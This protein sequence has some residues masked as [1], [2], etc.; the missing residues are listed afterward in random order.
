MRRDSNSLSAKMIGIDNLYNILMQAPSVII[1]T[2]GKNHLLWLANAIAFK[3]LDRGAEIINKP[4]VEAIPEIKGA[5]I[6][7][8]C[9]HVLNTGETCY[10][11]AV[12]I[13]LFRSNIEEKRYI[14]ISYQPYY[15]EG[16]HEPVG[17]F[18][19]SHDVTKLVEAQK[20][21]AEIEERLK[22][23]LEAADMGT[24]DYNLI[25]DTMI[26]SDGL[27]KLFGLSPKEEFSYKIFIDT[28]IEADR[29][30]THRVN[31]DVIHLKN[32]QSSYY[33]QYRIRRVNDGKLRWIR[34]KGKVYADQHGKP[35]RFIG[36]L[37]DITKEK[38]AE[39]RSRYIFETVPLSI[40]EKDYSALVVE[41]NKLT[42]QYGPKLKEYFLD[43]KHE[44]YRLMSLVK[45]ID[46]NRASLKMFEAEKKEQ[47]LKGLSS[48]FIDET[49]PFFIDELIAIANNDPSFHAEFKLSTLKGRKITCSTTIVFPEDGQYSNVLVSRYDISELV[50]TNEDLQQFVHMISHD[51]KEPVRKISMYIDRLQKELQARVNEATKGYIDRIQ[52]GARRID[53]IIDGVLAYSRANALE[54]LF[55]QVDLN[56]LLKDVEADLEL[57]IQQK[58]ARLYYSDL[59]QVYAVPLLLY[60]VF[61]NLIS[62]S[63]K[64]SQAGVAPNIIITSAI[65]NKRGHPFTRIIL[66][67]NGIGF[68][69][70]YSEKVFDS[71]TRLH[72][73]DK[74]EGAGLGLFICKTI[75]ER[76]GGSITAKSAQNK[77]TSFEIL[78]PVLA[79]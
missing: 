55:E 39:E 75:V 67:D 25:T 69:Q 32:N 70:K 38:T 20:E 63:L 76:L 33:L 7:E 1:I 35:Y 8:L 45:I 57:V 27:K 16:C 71:F 17:V 56:V 6:V 12:P 43:N 65:I 73:K 22:S 77:G 79:T 61:Y 31:Q 11:R 58:S 34:A 9:D 48:V 29:A 10:G 3:L 41:L 15:E 68:E 24:W 30:H 28:V 49:C 62:N 4:L 14:D 2:K 5:G 51:L 44:V 64:F 66:Q 53:A 52:T 36:T 50:R 26:A 13:T 37:L 72:A 74:Y 59:L 18:T 46:T 60:D 21:T 78:F 47:L 23:A 42:N 40:W 19:I 54:G